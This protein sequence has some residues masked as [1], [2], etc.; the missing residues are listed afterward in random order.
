M[1][2]WLAVMVLIGARFAL[3]ALVE[4]L[5]GWWLVLALAL[6]GLRRVLCCWSF[7]L[8]L[9]IL[10]WCLAVNPNYDYG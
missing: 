5:W 4:I 1:E 7:S 3:W 6:L 2:R 8:G 9:M 10:W